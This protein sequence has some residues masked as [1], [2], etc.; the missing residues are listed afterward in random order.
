VRRL[1]A[2]R[3]AVDPDELAPEV[4]LTDDLAADSLDLVDLAIGLEEEF[5]ITVTE[6]TIRELRT[7]RQVVDVAEARA[8]E[9]RAQEAETE[10]ER[11]PPLIW[12]RVLPPASRPS[13]S[14]ERAD[15]LTPYT[16]QTIIDSALRAGAGARL[17]VHVP[18]N[19]AEPTVARLRAEFAWLRVRHIG[20]HVRRDPH[21]PPVGVAA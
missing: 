8:R 4:S 18:P 10:S 19:L 13:R 15:W 21:L 1:V 5:G 12:A 9:R 6:S 20:V 2:E 16:A 14:L 7:Y 3:L 11:T 17:D